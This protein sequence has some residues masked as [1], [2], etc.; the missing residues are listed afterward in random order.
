MIRSSYGA[1]L[2]AAAHG[3]EDVYPVIVT[4]IEIA[5]GVRTAEQTK[6]YREQGEL[7][8]DV[9]LTIDAEGVY[10]SSVNRDFRTP[11]EK[12]LLGHV[13]WIREMLQKKVIRRLQWCDTGDMIA[14]GH[15]KGNIDRTALINTMKGEQKYLY[16]TRT[17]EPVRGYLLTRG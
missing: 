9:T 15:A 6:R 3:M 7:E 4:L 11:S 13:A 17:H 10:K 5:S 14:D 2:L 16:E 8:F 1:E 12:T